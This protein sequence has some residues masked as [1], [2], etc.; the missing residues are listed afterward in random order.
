ML[1]RDRERDR[2]RNKERERER[3]FWQRFLL[4]A[5]CSGL[6]VCNFVFVFGG[7]LIQFSSSFACNWAPEV[8]AGS[9]W[10]LCPVR[11]CVCVPAAANFSSGWRLFKLSVKFL[12]TYIFINQDFVWKIHPGCAH[13]LCLSSA[14]QTAATTTTC[15][16]TAANLMSTTSVALASLQVLPTVW[17]IFGHVACDFYSPFFSPASTY[18]Q[19]LWPWLW[20]VRLWTACEF[21]PLAP[22]IQVIKY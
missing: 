19:S 5:T 10:N 9:T 22:I 11:P 18:R 6:A 12:G 16:R 2:Q 3:I 20:L 17:R 1:Q 21:N 14:Q 15:R 13:I 4:A 8:R 7:H